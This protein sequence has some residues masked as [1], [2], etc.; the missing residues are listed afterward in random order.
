MSKKIKN[1]HLIKRHGKWHINKRIAGSAK[2]Y[3]RS[4]KT[5]NIE[6]ARERRD[7]ILLEM[8][9]KAQVVEKARDV[10]TIRKKYLDTLSDD[11]REFGSSPMRMRLR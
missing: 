5:D 1:K 6:I 2:I 11:E 10:L 7:Q 4:L 8:K 9:N 3:R